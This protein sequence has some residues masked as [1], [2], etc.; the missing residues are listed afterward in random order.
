MKK[1]LIVVFF[2]LALF[3]L[4]GCS[5]SINTEKKLSNDQWIQ[6]L[7][8]LDTEITKQHPNLFKYI[9]EE[10]WNK[11]IKNL[12][13]EVPNLS[14]GS[15]RLKIAQIIV[16]IGD[17]H[18]F[19]MPTDAVTPIGE[20]QIPPEELVE[21]PVKCEFF[22][23]GIRV[24]QCDSNYK[25]IL[26]AKIVSINN[27]DINEVIDKIATL[28][29]HDY[30]NKQ[31][32]LFM[33]KEYMNTYDFLKFFKIVDNNKAEYVFETD[34]KEKITLKLNAE[35]N[36]SID[37]ITVDKKEMK[38]NELREG[39]NKRYWHRNFEEDNVLYLKF[40]SFVSNAIKEEKLYPDFNEFQ[41][42]LIGEINKHNYSK[43]IIDLRNNKGGSRKIL[44]AMTDMVKYRTD[45]KGEEIYVITGKFTNSSA[46]LWAWDL[47]S[48]KGATVLGEETGG[49]INLF[50]S[51]SQYVELPNSKFKIYYSSNEIISKEGYNGGVKPDIEVIQKYEDYINGID[52]CYEYIL[53]IE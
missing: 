10:E 17:A 40:N 42:S 49:N 20:E 8:Y 35:K 31:C 26:G 29:A 53:P 48:R 36:K 23:D 11:S 44:D 33:A 38:T 13:S 27:T 47:Q 5:S 7:D 1:I 24:I 15:I 46:V 9:S 28:F 19:V 52:T 14:D 2:T 12:K 32:A 45:L 16:S 43:F 41:E 34:N 50:P 37:Y 18:T 25:E 51:N 6:D 3:I 22:E 4:S 39:D 30:Q 21:F